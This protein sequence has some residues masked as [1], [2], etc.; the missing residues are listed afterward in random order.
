MHF[1]S[2]I[3]SKFVSIYELHT[4]L[5][6]N[7]DLVDDILSIAFI[8]WEDDI[9]YNSYGI[10]GISAIVRDAVVEIEYSYYED[11]R[12]QDEDELKYGTLTIHE[13]EYT[14][15]SEDFKMN[16]D[17]LIINEVEVNLKTKTIT[18]K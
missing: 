2:K 7:K 10:S 18:I 9:D 15:D 1:Q 17:Q 13:P 3:E 11:D 16:K 6:I 8:K 4:F 5:K 14:I 12:G